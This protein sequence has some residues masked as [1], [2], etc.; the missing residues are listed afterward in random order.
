MYIEQS[1]NSL[2]KVEKQAMLICNG[3]SLK[4]DL[5]KIF[6]KRKGANIYAMNFFATTA[7]F[8]QLKPEFYVFADPMFWR[9]D[10]KEEIKN[11]RRN[12]IKSLSKVNWKMTIL[13]TVS[14]EDYFKEIFNDHQYIKISLK[15]IYFKK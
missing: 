3:P 6:E 10:V 13:C 5:E 4:F 8:Q 12:L 2:V 15:I 9:T 11:K 1:K 7:S 14:G